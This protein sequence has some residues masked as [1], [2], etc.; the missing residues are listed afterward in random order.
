MKPSPLLASAAMA[1]LL[2]FSV[3]HSATAA[4]P[5][6][7]RLAWSDE[8]DGATLDTN[9]WSQRQP[10]RRRDA[11]NTADAIRVADG[12]LTLSTYT[13]GGKHY[14]GMI[15]THGKF[16]R[17]V[18]YWEA[19]IKFED[20]PGEW[21]AFW[22]HTDR[23]GRPVGDPATA[24]MEIDVVEHRVLDKGGKDISAHAQHTLHWDGYGKDH[25]SKGHTVTDPSLARGFHTYGLE[26]TE[27][28]YRFYIDDRLTWT[29][30]TPVSKRP[31]FILLSSEIEDKGWAGAIPTGGYGPR[32]STKTKMTVD[33]V[34]FHE[35]R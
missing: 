35:R 30:P 17:A 32:E 8:F 11:I 33:Y 34:R 23:M 31:Q 6:G 7:Y 5:E 22:I 13:E 4:P 16:E 18:G 2:P 29:A 25:K 3:P 9:K 21:S 26:W 10:G 28:E 27:K 20:S 19:R 14:T 1:A 15:G 24:G 12:Q